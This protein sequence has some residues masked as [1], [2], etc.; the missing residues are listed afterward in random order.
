MSHIHPSSTAYTGR[1]SLSYSVHTLISGK[2]S[3]TSSFVKAISVNELMRTA[4]RSITQSSQPVRRRRP[5]TVPNSWP[6][7]TSRSPVSSSNSVGNGPLPTRV[8]YALVMPTI[9]VR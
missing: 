9:L 5:V 3:S 6:M 2:V 8:V 4:L 1:P 7:S